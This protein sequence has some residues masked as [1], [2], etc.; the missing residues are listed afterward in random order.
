MN[1][2]NYNKIRVPLPN[3]KMNLKLATIAASK[4]DL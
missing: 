2:R 3:P 1:Y 4:A